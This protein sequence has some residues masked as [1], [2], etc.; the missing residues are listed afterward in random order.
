MLTE[1]GL[2]RLWD[3]NP[4][5]AWAFAR[6]WLPIL[7]QAVAPCYGYG[8]ERLPAK[9]GCVLAVNH[10]SAIDP[11]VLG[12][13]SRR[14]IYYMAKAELLEIPMVSE[15]L[16]WMGAF[17]V[18]RGEGDRDALR[19]AR[20]L[21]AHGHAVGMF[22]EGTRQRLGYPGSAQVG[23]AM[24]A[25]QEQVPLV[26]CGLDT[27]RWSFRNRRACACV[28]GH[29]LDLSGLPRNG[30]GYKEATA[31]VEREVHRVWWLAAQA[32]ADGFPEELADGAKRARPPRAGNGYPVVDAP[33]WPSE[34]WARGPLGP[35]FPGRPR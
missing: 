19:V 33:A 9:G 5:K 27:F 4:E 35:V 28:F 8:L 31:M 6:Y 21:V 3:E 14:T 23:A 16:R 32:V 25:M 24:V 10:L 12:V 29:P 13:F 17:A 2:Y 22:V 11:L 1:L 20:W 18:R 26:P 30:R 34:E 15:I 7:V